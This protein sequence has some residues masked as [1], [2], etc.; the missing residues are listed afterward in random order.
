MVRPCF[1]CGQLLKAN[2]I[3]AP[4]RPVTKPRYAILYSSCE[5]R[6]DKSTL[7]PLNKHPIP[8][9]DRKILGIDFFKWN[10]KDYLIIVDHLLHKGFVR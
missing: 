9:W 7:E 6:I 10:N 1:L 2:Y 4:E 3:W 8:K 5:Q